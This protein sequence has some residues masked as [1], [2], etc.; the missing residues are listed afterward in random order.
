M[1]YAASSFEEQL[2]ALAPA[3][4]AGKVRRGTLAAARPESR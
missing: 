3:V 1:A 2:G 4:E